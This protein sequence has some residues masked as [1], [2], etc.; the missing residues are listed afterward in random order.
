M[1]EFRDAIALA[2][3]DNQSLDWWVGLRA[4]R[5]LDTPEMQSIRTALREM[6]A[7]DGE[8]A[9]AALSVHGLPESVIDWV[10]SE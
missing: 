4:T 6:A 5:V 9:K 3:S 1:N 10:V 7:H 2:L 8:W